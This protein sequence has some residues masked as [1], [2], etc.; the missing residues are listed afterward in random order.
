VK[1]IAI[2]PGADC[3]YAWTDD[4]KVYHEQSGVWKLGKI[5]SHAH[6]YEALTLQVDAYEPDYVFFEVA[7]WLQGK[8]AR[9]WHGGYLAAIEIYCLGV[10]VDL[11]TVTPDE[12]KKLATGHR[13]A[14]KEEMLAYAQ[15]RFGFEGPKDHNAVDALWI[16]NWGLDLIERRNE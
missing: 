10:G 3:G 11:E 14:A 1:C 16:L 8:A 9:R 12:V 7:Q 13:A 2:D 5:T 15:N 6:R 4:G